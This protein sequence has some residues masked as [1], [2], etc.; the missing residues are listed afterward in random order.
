VEKEEAAPL[1]AFPGIFILFFWRILSTKS[2][3]PAAVQPS[4]GL[5]QSALG[6]DSSSPQ[7]C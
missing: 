4:F 6:G 7:A 1:A 3:E 5:A 2:A